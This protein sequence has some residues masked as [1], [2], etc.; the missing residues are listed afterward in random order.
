MNRNITLIGVL[1]ILFG[2]ILGAFGAHGL[3]EMV[4]VTK[5]D[6]F[7]TGVRFQMYHGILLI[8]I[9]FNWDKIFFINKAPILIMYL[10]VA[11]FSGSIYLLVLGAAL[12]QSWSFLGPVT[13][14]GGTLLIISWIIVVFRL[15]SHRQDS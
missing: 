8:I 11:L 5:L 1:L 9:G 2:I 4:D 12:E 13:P 7:E 10:G 15:L 3:K 6:A 14:I